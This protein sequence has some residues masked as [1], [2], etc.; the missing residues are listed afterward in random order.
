MAY[1]KMLSLSFVTPPD[2]NM[3]V[4]NILSCCLKSKNIQIKIHDYNVTVLYECET[5]SFTLKEEHRLRVLNF[6]FQE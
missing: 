1:L 5:S 6:G 3:Q 2:I 4:Q